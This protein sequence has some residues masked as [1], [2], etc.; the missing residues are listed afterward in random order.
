MCL[1]GLIKLILFRKG[2]S[3][4][5]YFALGLEGCFKPTSRLHPKVDPDC[6]LTHSCPFESV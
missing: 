5:V 1:S 2:K 3:G 6:R 4:D